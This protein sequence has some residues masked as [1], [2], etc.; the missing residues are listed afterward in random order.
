MKVEVGNATSGTY[1]T[2][3]W[4]VPIGP[5]SSSGRIRPVWVKDLILTTSRWTKRL[6]SGASA[7]QCEPCPVLGTYIRVAK[8]TMAVR[9]VHHL[10]FQKRWKRLANISSALST[11]K[12]GNALALHWNGEVNQAASLMKMTELG[13]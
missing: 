1:S 8:G 2:G 9:R 12:C 10:R 7:K 5:L 11:R 13:T 6:S 3:W 4:K